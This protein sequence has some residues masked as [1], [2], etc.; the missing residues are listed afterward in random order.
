LAF[1]I[2]PRRSLSDRDSATP[3]FRDTPVRAVRTAGDGPKAVSQQQDSS[4]GVHRLP[5]HRHNR[6][7]VHSRLSRRS[8]IGPE[9]PRSKLVP[10][11]PFLPASTVYSAE[12]AIRRP[13]AF[14]GLQVCCT[15][16]PVMG[17]ARFPS[18]CTA[19]W[20]PADVVFRCSKPFPL[21]K[22]LRSFSLSGS[23]P[24]RHRGVPPPCEGDPRS[25][26][27]HSLSSFGSSRIVPCC[28]GD[29]SR[30]LDLR[31]FFH[32]RVRC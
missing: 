13:R 11:L 17:F 24:S 32:R 6:H 20:Q 2:R 18:S 10:S 19:F 28:H 22:T 5:L 30:V 1:T 27:E 31:A 25:P 14:D 12:P 4:H 26:S 7:C 9:P 15:L 16:Q 23:C 3:L 21:A 8:G 29:N